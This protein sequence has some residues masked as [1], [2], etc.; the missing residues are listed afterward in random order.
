M[1]N[2]GWQ[3][4]EIIF[5]DIKPTPSKYEKPNTYVVLAKRIRTGLVDY[6]LGSFSLS[7]L[8]KAMTKKIGRPP[9]KSVQVRKEAK[10]FNEG[11]QQALKDNE[12]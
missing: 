11:Y 2:N 12:L 3:D 4:Y 6:I 1:A 7:S 10:A 8:D 9:A 5:E